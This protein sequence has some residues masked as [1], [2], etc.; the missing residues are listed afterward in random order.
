MLP[1][2]T[3]TIIYFNDIMVLAAEYHL[4]FNFIQNIAN[5][6]VVTG[7]N[8]LKYLQETKG[9]NEDFHHHEEIKI[10]ATNHQSKTYWYINVN[11]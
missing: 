8:L 5:D 7:N 1:K 9:S 4:L 10:Y 2:D 11:P 6:F 3:L